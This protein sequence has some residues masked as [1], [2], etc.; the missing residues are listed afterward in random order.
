MFA[1]KKSKD[2]KIQE[3][4]VVFFPYTAV[5]FLHVVQLCLAFQNSI[6]IFSNQFCHCWKRKERSFD[7]QIRLFWGLRGLLVP[8]HGDCSKDGNWIRSSEKC[9]LDQTHIFPHTALTA[10][11]VNLFTC[12][13]GGQAIFVDMLYCRPP[14]WVQYLVFWIQR[15]IQHNRVLYK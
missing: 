15:I 6:C 4:Q 14:H 3:R 1:G 11:F 5:V 10:F 8:N 13:S 7:H 12:T 2:L 9:S